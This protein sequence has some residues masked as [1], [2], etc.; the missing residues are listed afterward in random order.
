[1]PPTIRSLRRAVVIASLLALGAASIAGLGA[2]SAPKPVG[3]AVGGAAARAADFEID[4]V[5]STLNYRVRHFGVSY[6]FGRI[7]KPTGAFFFD[8]ADASKSHLEV[9]AE[10]KNMDAGD[11]ARNSFLL[12][13]DFFNGREFPKAEFKSTSIKRIDDAT[14]EAAGTFT[15]HGVTKPVTVRLQ[16]Y[17]EK[18]TTKFGYRAGFLCTFTVKR[19]DYG[20]DLF[21]A[22][23]TLGDE[24]QITASLEGVRE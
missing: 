23:G 11:P 13:P 17:T 6:F 14:Y 21:V 10:I 15:L 24:V 2:S 8:P 22:D 1:M 20:M 12:S 9:A 16:E 19:S 5:H 4:L 7:N 18:Q 3:A